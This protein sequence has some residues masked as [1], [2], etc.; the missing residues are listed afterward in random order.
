MN[1]Q[2]QDFQDKVV[3]ITGGT[4]GI[5]KALSLR[6]ASEGARVAMNYL[7]RTDQA[8]Q[9]LKRLLRSCDLTSALRHHPERE[10]FD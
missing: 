1:Q 2:G 5:G 6:L 10:L 3:L 9:T 7:S 4:R 8:E